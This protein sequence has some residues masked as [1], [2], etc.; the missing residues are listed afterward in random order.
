MRIYDSKL[1]I[2]P[3]DLIAE[4]ECSHRLHLEWSVL[5]NLIEEPEKVENEELNLLIK[6][7]KVHEVNLANAFAR[8]EGF[9]KIPSTFEDSELIPVAFEKT[10]NAMREG[11]ETIYMP[12][13]FDGEFVGYPDFLIKARDFEGNPILDSQ[14]QFVY[15]PV[16]AKSARSEKRAAVLQIAAYAYAM[17]KMG[18][19]RPNKVHLWLANDKKWSTLASDVMDLGEL[20][21]LRVKARIAQLNEIPNPTWDY[22]REACTRCRWVKHCDN[23]RREA[24][25]LSLIQ[26][27]RSS[28][29]LA[30]REVGI[31]TI[32]DMALASD[33]LRTSG[34]QDIAKETFENLRSQADIQLRGRKVANGIPIFEIKEKIGFG[35]IPQPSIGDVWF[36]MEGDPYAEQGEGLEYMFGFVTRE[37]Q[38]FKFQTFDA[39]NREQEKR[40][41]GEF[42]GF[43][44][45]RLEAYPDMHVYHYASYEPSALLR[46]AQRHGY[47]EYEVDKLIRGAVFVDLYSVVRKTL[48]FSTESLSIKKIEP[49]FYEGNRDKS[50]SSSIGSVVAFEDALEQLNNGSRAGFEKRLQEIKDYN[51]DDCRSTQR[52]DQWLRELA[53]TQGINFAEAKVAADEKWKD[54][55]DALKEPIAIQLM[56]DVPVKH[57][58][59]D[60]YQQGKAMVAAAIEYHHRE[61][62]PAWWEIFD[63]ATSE[64]FELENANDVVFPSKVE[65]TDWHVEG[66]KNPR[67]QITFYASEGVDLRH[68]LDFEHIPQAL[69]ETAPLG[70]KQISG[71]NRGFRSV[72]IIELESDLVKVEE[73][74]SKLG[75]WDEEPFALLPGAPIPTFVIKKILRQE[76]GQSILELEAA[77]E[78]YFPPT[79][80]NDI[81]LRRLP[82]QKSGYLPQADSDVESVTQ[83]LIDSDNSYIAVQGPPGTG[84]TFVGAHV[85]SKLVKLGWRIGVVAQSHAVIENLLNSVRKIDSTIPIAK[86]GQSRKNRP[87]YHV[88]D[89]GDWAISQT[90]GY[91][92]GGTTWNFA[93]MGIRA[94]H[95]DLVVIDEAGQYSLANALVSLSCASRALLLG[96]PQQLPHVSQGKHPEPIDNSVLKHVLGDNKTMPAHLGYFLSR[97]FRLH[98]LL[99]KPV[100]RLQYEDRLSADTRCSKRQLEGIDPGL[101]VIEVEHFGNT[102]KSVEEV[103]T[104]VKQVSLLMNRAW[105]DTDKSGSPLPARGLD[106]QDILIIAAYNNQVRLIKQRLLK[107]NL[108]KIKV[109]TI[110]KFQGQEAAVVLISMATSSSE[111][112]PRGIEFLLSPNRINVA[113]SR[114]QWACFLMRSPQLSLMEPNSADG[115]VMLGKF[116]T[117]CKGSSVIQRSERL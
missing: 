90:A 51:E 84:K 100:S 30:L 70:F 14:G 27:I 117:L 36:D 7:G 93:S 69:Y 37:N 45:S 105:I 82:R 73:R 116:I 3:R 9:R 77:G 33:E 52:L 102:T 1:L 42:I 89:V 68:I 96:D 40:A 24:E 6:H 94:L 25:D 115:M 103:D 31:K 63:K 21:F 41:F 109:G 47:L 29:R 61:D 4:L 49:V 55:D 46:L 104:L 23:G 87:E 62:R 95:L 99:A 108:S 88:D 58:E 72:E 92:I 20:F 74:A 107:E 32:N 15:D 60:L 57:S 65:C 98:P 8:K 79:A 18:M 56:K 106:Q 53:S 76:I 67:R 5:N 13:L 2:S 71:S 75:A 114:A 16:D 81:L 19:P 26:G 112:L 59:R 10:V 48:R 66:K 111:D 11:A 22:P 54:D 17:E 28:T 110:D 35:L 83:A 101:H 34:K 85:I 43:I 91:V 44:S 113:I 86:K 38:E 50:V 64:L 78:D 12:T 97:T 39:E 80:H